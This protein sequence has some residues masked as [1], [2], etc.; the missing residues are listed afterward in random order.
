MYK[1]KLI[2]KL[3]EMSDIARQHLISAKRNQRNI[4]IEKLQ[5]LENRNSGPY[6]VL[7]ILGK[8][9]IQILVR[10]KPKIVNINRLRL[11]Y[12]SLLAINQKKKD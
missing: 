9:N 7:E 6:E 4:M 8:G 10:N 5:K 2:T 11:S 1:T 12:I 3:H